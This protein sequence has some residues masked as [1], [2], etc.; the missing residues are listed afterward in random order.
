LKATALSGSAR[1]LAEAGGEGGAAAAVNTTGSVN[2]IGVFISLDTGLAS[3]AMTERRTF[4]DGAAIRRLTELPERLTEF[5]GAA[6]SRADNSVRLAALLASGET[7]GAFLAGGSAPPAACPYTG[8]ATSNNPNR[9]T[10]DPNLPA[11]LRPETRHCLKPALIR[12]HDFFIRQMKQHILL[13]H[14]QTPVAD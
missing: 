1:K 5:P 14:E 3:L 13:N 11:T 2:G 10:T 7:L 12:F 9:Q 8:E 4:S 6:A